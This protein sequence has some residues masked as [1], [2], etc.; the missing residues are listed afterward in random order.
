[1]ANQDNTNFVNSIVDAQKQAADTIV[2]NAKKFTNGNTIVNETVQKG[3]EWYKNWL[4]NQKSILSNTT[5]KTANMTG[6]MQNNMNQMSEFYQNWYNQ[7]AN[8]AKQMWEMNTNYFQNATANNN[9]ANMNPMQ[10]WQNMQNNMNTMMS[11]INNTNQWMNMMQQWNSMFNMDAYKKSTENWTSL[12]NQYQEILNSNWSK[13]QENMQNGTAQD[14]YKSMINA[15]ESF[16]KFYEMWTPMWKSIQDKTFNMDMY[17]QWMNPI[18]YKD[19]M[20]KYLGFMPESS[21]N[22]MQQMTTMMQDG[23]KQFS[24]MG[25]QGYQQM[26]SM[27]GNMMPAMDASSMFGNMMNG[28]NQMYNTVNEAAAPF[29]KMFATN[30]HTKSMVEWQD[31]ANRMAVYNIKNAELQY[32]MYTQGSKVMDKLAENVMGKIQSGEEINSMMAL[33]Q[34]WMN[35]SDKTFVSLFE[36]DEYSQLMAEVSAM[37]I[38]LKKDVEMQMEKFMVGVPVATRSEMD[39]LY[40]TIYELKKQVRQMEKMM[41]LGNEEETTEE[42]KTTRRATTAKK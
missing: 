6:N 12:Y 32:M 39:E 22:Y 17:K 31:I 7:Q 24:N 29:T 28:Y 33:F 41:E 23:M 36:S 35:I 21:R 19:L 40:K 26:R 37:Q 10:M 16:T 30:Q 4:D 20:D 3:T 14:A 27:M 5:E 2:E 8:W 25:T 18:A 11:G 9:A 38:K 15:T 42:P 1:M 13:M 34:E